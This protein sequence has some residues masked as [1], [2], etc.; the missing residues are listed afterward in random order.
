MTVPK[1]IYKIL[2]DFYLFYTRLDQMKTIM[3]TDVILRQFYKSFN[4]IE[5]GMAFHSVDSRF[6]VN[7]VS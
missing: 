2:S 1:N 5:V 6:S 7:L 3:T 4:K